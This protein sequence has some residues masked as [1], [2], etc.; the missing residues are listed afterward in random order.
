MFDLWPLRLS[1]IHQG[2]CLFLH[3][4]RILYHLPV[5]LAKQNCSCPFFP[6]TASS[7]VPHHR[8]K[9]HKNSCMTKPYRR[10]TAK[11][12]ELVSMNNTRYLSYFCPGAKDKRN[13]KVKAPAFQ[14]A[15]PHRFNVVPIS[16]CHSLSL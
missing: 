15:L 14:K 8:K 10:I 13:P 1:F 3:Y 5:S 11:K 9:P 6:T 16:Y 12:Q 7:A 4:V 2:N